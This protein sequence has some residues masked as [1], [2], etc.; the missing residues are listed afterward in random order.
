MK[1]GVILAVTAI[2]LSTSLSVS[3]AV[4]ESSGETYANQVLA[5]Q[6]PDKTASVIGSVQSK[7]ALCQQQESSDC[8]YYEDVLSVLNP[9][10]EAQ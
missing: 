6:D 3:Q 2:M 5:L 7:L 9:S 8:S 1:K 10:V 4:E